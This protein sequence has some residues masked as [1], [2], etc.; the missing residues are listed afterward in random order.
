MQPWMVIGGVTFLVSLGAFLIRPRD[1]KW[2]MKLDRPRWLVFEPLIPVIWTVVFVTGA[3]S[4]TIVWNHAPGTL[5]TWLLMAVYLLLEVVT[6]AYIPATLRTR[7]LAVGTT[8]GAIGVV[9]GIALAIAV[10]YISPWATLLLLPYLAWSPIGTLTTGQMID[11]N[12]EA[13]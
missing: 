8:L 1:I 4:A 7:S 11:L 13:E 10:W 6:V 2:E 5:T 3:A 12:P 9:I